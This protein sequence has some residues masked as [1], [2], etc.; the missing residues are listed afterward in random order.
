MKKLY[1]LI[2]LSTF[3]FV[4][5]QHSET[6]TKPGPADDI[7][8]VVLNRKA[9]IDQDDLVYRDYGFA[10]KLS[11]NAT[12]SIARLDL[13]LKEENTAIIYVI[14]L[15]SKE[16]IKLCD[17][18]PGQDITYTTSSDGIYQMIAMISTG[19]IIDLTPDVLVETSI[20]GETSGGFLPLQ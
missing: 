11:E 20:T 19:E 13:N 10:L 9:P 7:T 8:G 18:Q 2:L 17:Y 14:N 6:N 4:G 12:L 16:I 5:C 1:Y 3:L 15:E